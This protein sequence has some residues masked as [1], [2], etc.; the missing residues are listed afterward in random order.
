[1]KKIE[2]TL[3]FLVFSTITFILNGQIT[4]TVGSTGADYLTLKSA[5]DA[6]NGGTLTGAVTLQIVNNTTETVS[7]VL[8]RSGSGSANYSSVTIYPTVSGITITGSLAAPLIDLNGADNVIFDGRMNQTGST[9]DLII[10]NTIVSAVANTS[11]IRFINDA[12]FNTVRYCTIKGSTT[13]ATTALGGIFF[14][15]STNITPNPLGNSNN[16]IEYNN[17]TGSSAG[18]PVKVIFSLGSAIGNSEN[19]IRNNQFYDFLHKSI[20]SFGIYLADYSIKWMITGNSF[21]E[22]TS[23]TPTTSQEYRIININAATNLEI[24]ISNNFIGGSSSSCNGT[25]WTKTAMNT[26]F[27]AIYLNTGATSKSNVQNNTIKNFNWSNSSSAA[28]F[29]I[30]IEG[31]AVDIGTTTG[32]TIG[33]STGNGSIT[34]TGGASGTIVYGIYLN[35][36]NPVDCQNN[37]IGSITTANIETGVS[38]F[39]GIWKTT[40]KAGETTISNNLI[41]SETTLNSIYASTAGPHNVYG[42][43]SEGT[44][45]AT[46]Q[47]NSI[48]NLTNRSTSTAGVVN[49][50]ATTSIS[51]TTTISNN[52]MHELT[53]ANANATASI[54]GIVASGVGLKS[55]T[56]NTMYNLTNTNVNAT[57]S[58]FGVYCNSGVTGSQNLSGNTIYGLFAYSGGANKLTGI[59]FVSTGNN[60]TLSNNTINDIS[61]YGSYSVIVNLTGISCSFGTSGPNLIS[62]NLVQGLAIFNDSPSSIIYGITALAGSGDYYNNIIS[63]GGNTNT[64][65]FGIKES[66]LIN[67]T[68]KFYFN[69]V[70]IEGH[71]ESDETNLS[72][73]LYSALSSNT[74]DFR[75]NVFVNTRSTVSGTNKHYAI[76]LNYSVSTNLTL[77]FNDYFVSGTGG[78]ILGRYA[79]ANKT[80]L[81]IV[82]LMDIES[83][84]VYPKFAYPGGSVAIN[85]LTF[86]VMEGTTITSVPTD[87]FSVTRPATPN[88]GALE[89]SFTPSGTQVDIYKSGIVQYSCATLG[90]A[91]SRIN[92][93]S[94][95]GDLEIRIN[96]STVET[97][98]A[99]LYQSGYSNFASTSSYNSIHIY[100]TATEVTI[101]G[102]LQAPLIA[103]YGAD[104]VNIDGRVNGS[105][106]QKDMTIVN[107]SASDV[108]GTSTIKIMYSTINNMIKYCKIKGST[109]SANSGVVCLGEISVSTYVDWIII[110][111]NDFTSATNYNRPYCVIYSTASYQNSAT[112]TISNNHF[113]D[114]VNYKYSR[115]INLSTCSNW[116]ITGN[117]FYETAPIDPPIGVGIINIIYS[118]GNDL[119]VHI[120]G[121]YIGGSMPHCGGQPW[122]KSETGSS[123]F[124]AF[125]HSGALS[126]FENNFIQ[127]FDWKNNSNGTD[128]TGISVSS[129][130]IRL[131]TITGN[132]IGSGSGT[133]SIKISN[134]YNFSFYGVNIAFVDAS[135]TGNTIGSITTTNNAAYSGNFYGIYKSNF[136]GTTTVSN[137]TIGSLSTLN[138]IQAASPSTGNS[139]TMYGIYSLGTDITNVSDNTIAN[140]TNG[141]TNATS[142]NIN[143]I[144]CKNGPVNIIDNTVRNLTISNANSSSD[145]VASVIGISLPGTSQNLV[146]G[147]TIFNLSNN[148]VSFAGSIFG[149]YFNANT[150]GPNEISK[151]FIHDLSVQ[152]T[153]SNL[154]TVFGMKIASG[155]NSC[156]NNIVS[157]G[158]NTKTTLYGIY[159]TG[160]ASNNNNLY[161]NT[162]YIAGNPVSGA[163]NKSYA[164]YSNAATNTRDFR[165]N[166]FYNG[167][168][169]SG[170]TNL[171]YAVFLNYGSSSNLTVGYNDYFVNGSGGVLGSFDNTNQTQVPI[172]QDMDIGSIDLDPGWELPG[173]QEAI[174]YKPIKNHNGTPIAS[175][176]ND[177]GDFLRKKPT[178]GAWELSLNFWKGSINN[179]WGLAGNWTDNLVPTSG[180]SIVFDESPLNHC[181]LDQD[182]VVKDIINAQGIYR[183]VTNGYK[184]TINGNWLFTN[185]AQIDA[186]TPG[187]TIE[188]SGILPHTIDNDLFTGN[189]LQNLAIDNDNGT[190]LNTDFTI[191]N[192]LTVNAGK[193][194]T[195][196]PSKELTVGDNLVN[197]AGN[198]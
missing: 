120:S 180:S 136:L 108:P 74:R 194:F 72:Y 159:E 157:L 195:V 91:F 8:N 139:Q 175:I 156:F 149:L 10:Q 55:I 171:H 20:A 128:W 90:E 172:V 132:T 184:L 126:I 173:G 122:T 111:N 102:N 9:P 110:D 105:G 154:A 109:T 113:Y 80:G 39:Y 152:G 131:M 82:P 83:L 118:T 191:S 13:V 144:Y 60:N 95:T 85:Y 4:R 188:I 81:P 19:I 2:F 22:T 146:S 68:N 127:N 12:T 78:G 125:S 49:G 150:T 76:W 75:N 77:A 18:R 28:W 70:Y 141:T 59:L 193:S 37:T 6:I 88:M 29:G 176:S 45:N 166:I 58:I 107:I 163:I 134:N 186:T 114:F 32:N 27:T 192:N 25:A 36:Q 44:A 79:G 112:R 73:A 190:I 174:N 185:G 138:S 26:I 148:H 140:L 38:S 3:L 124:V 142:G 119:T 123:T 196:A 167:R 43:L 1:M 64:A 50:I 30:R 89:P 62:S 133:G 71:L 101:S 165:N 181:H 183:V 160:A 21:Y 40:G 48:A 24:N 97:T 198:K 187:S 145:E 104:N 33:A 52:T 11:T 34:V 57:V 103:L 117:S 93:G 162:V 182:R 31:G 169:T 92:D 66:G 56:G 143:G 41:G 14:F 170:G 121:N 115:S 161:F 96:T 179:D 197:P 116:Y 23:F 87:Y 47:N 61:T 7:A 189:E 151:N 177:Y 15:S 147:N 164:L 46:I 106:D 135:I 65:L 129:G 35:G 94:Y 63:L 69:T 51:G 54:G 168:S 17:I 153:N 98:T 5:F 158:G 130:V 84:T 178:A 53:N 42:I 137:N 155:A 16:T 86:E 67:T 99:I 100:P